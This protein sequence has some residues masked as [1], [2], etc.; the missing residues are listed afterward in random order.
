MKPGVKERSK[1][2]LHPIVSLPLTSIMIGM[3]DATMAIFQ[4][5]ES[6][7]MIEAYHKG[8]ITLRELMEKLEW[9]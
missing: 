9:Y 8:H 3:G 7:Q 4:M 1:Y 2:C 5:L 6:R